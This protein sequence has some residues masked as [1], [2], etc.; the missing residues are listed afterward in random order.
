[1]KRL[2]ALLLIFSLAGGSFVLSSLGGETTNSEAQIESFTV[3][4]EGCLTELTDESSSLLSQPVVFNTIINASSREYN[5]TRRMVSD[6]NGTYKIYVN[7]S[8]GSSRT[9][10]GSNCEKGY[11]IKYQIA[12]HV[13]R[14]NGPFR[15]I[16][17]HNGRHNACVQ[18]GY[19][20]KCTKASA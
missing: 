16:L 4:Q 12:V 1:M 15:V 8:E 7:T 18:T 17:Y 9:D 5:I 3:K 6:G 11:G 2:L 10:Q 19:D 20:S 14:G 13:P